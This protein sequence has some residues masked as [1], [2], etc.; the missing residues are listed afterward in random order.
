MRLDGAMITE[1][2]DSSGFMRSGVTAAR[3]V[4][5]CLTIAASLLLAIAP[6]P[7]HALI[8][9]KDITYKTVGSLDLKL[10]VRMPNG[11]GP[12]PA[13]MLIHGGR[14]ITGDKCQSNLLTFEKKYVAAG[15][16]VYTPNYRLAPPYPANPNLS[17]K[18]GCS[19]GT[20]VDVSPLQGNVYPAGQNDLADAVAWIRANAG[21]YKTVGSKVSAV[22]TSSGGTHAYMEAAKGLVNVGA[23]F[24]GP[25][26][27]DS[28][29]KSNGELTDYFGCS[30][31]ACPNVWAAASPINNV[32]SGSQPTD[33][34]NSSNELIPRAQADNYYNAL[35]NAGVTARET[36]IPGSKH[37]TGYVNY[38]LPD[39]KTVIQHTID[40]IRLNQ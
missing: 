39:G 28:T 23:G 2:T 9:K 19:D 26:T 4:L 22:G 14:N 7:A 18:V 1:G 31:N 13:I 38:V 25:T 33:I 35:R 12:F 32:V 24:S 17:P 11:A 15:F 27:F 20:T 5:L 3:R 10:D 37:A 40:Y 36:I 21:T 8:L 34:Y 30:Q 6:R 29:L 16:V